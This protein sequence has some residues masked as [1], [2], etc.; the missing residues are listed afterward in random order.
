MAAPAPPAPGSLNSS[1]VNI[2]S[3][4]DPSLHQYD[5]A[6]SFFSGDYILPQAAGWVVI[7][8]FGALFALLAILLVWIDVKF[9]GVIYNSEQFSTAGRDIGTGLLAV[10]IVSHWTWASILLQ[11]VS[12]GYFYGATGP[13]WICSGAMCVWL[14]AVVALELKYRAPH[15]HT[16]LECVEVR[17]GTAAHI[18]F[19]IF[20]VVTNLLVSTSMLQGCVAVVNALTGVNI[21][22]MAFIIP[23][24][25]MVYATVGG[26]KATFTTSYMH[27]VII[28]V[29][30]LIFMFVA[31]LP[32]SLLGGIDDIHDRLVQMALYY[33]VAD[34]KDGSYM[35][36]TSDSGIQFMF[37]F[38]LSGLSQMLVDQSFWQ[39]A[40]AAKPT[41]AA[42][43]YF[44]ASFLFMAIVFSLPI[45]LGLSA[46]ALDLPLSQTEA[47]EGLVAPASAFVL[48]GQA[49]PVLIIIICFMAVTSSGASEMVA[50]SSLFTF[51]V[52]RRY[53]NPKA[54]GPRLI[55]VSR[56][57]VVVWSIIMGI[58]MT[59]V[60]AAN[61]NINWLINSIG[62]FVGGAVPP[63]IFVLT[64]RRCNGAFATSGA[65]L[66]SACGIAAWLAYA[67]LGFGEVT[68]ATTG[69]NLPLL[70]GNVVSLGLSLLITIAGSLICPGKHFDWTNLNR[71]TK[72]EDTVT[73]PGAIDPS[74]VDTTEDQAIIGKARKKL[75]VLTVVGYLA[76]FILWPCLMAPAGGTW[77]VSYFRFYVVL[78]FVV[79]IIA[80][81][82]GIFLPLY[83]ARGITR[84]VLTGS[85]FKGYIERSFG[86]SRGAK[87]GSAGPTADPGDAKAVGDG[88][89]D[90][91]YNTLK[92]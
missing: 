28:F 74:A 32:N 85:T 80:S 5:G 36:I 48:L 37:I 83:E 39:S 7:L 51:D 65:V 10:D 58:A 15:A 91:S 24:S 27:T 16:M 30:C 82:I 70:T 63:L 64:W 52:Y 42:R 1:A 8:C 43:G 13:Y 31:F 59:V 55:W 62:V 78:A 73:R 49:G 81:I 23:I 88:V 33:P 6:T 18:V 14:F 86:G 17:W 57:G 50:I 45:C 22:A 40:I 19:F 72:T 71:I 11:C 76:L 25:T 21:Y 47:L 44:L 79:I 3:G 90:A 84:K 77:S 29:V 9:S 4:Q 69:Q 46:L 26:L 41:A 53:I 12:Y 54:L 56:I 35:T 67:R 2:F 75:W 20:A 68:I 38:F 87:S 92:A 34:Q 61:I 60:Q 66:G 89:K